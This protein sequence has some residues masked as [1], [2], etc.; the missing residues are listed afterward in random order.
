MIKNKL[1][2]IRHEKKYV[3]EIKEVNGTVAL[4]IVVLCLEVRV[5]FHS[6]AVYIQVPWPLN[7]VLVTATML[8]GAAGAGAYEMGMITDASSSLAFTGL[9][10]VVSAAGAIVVGFPP[11]VCHSQAKC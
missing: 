7:Y 1:K 5:V 10:V 11:L 2:E 3:Y 8:G 9:A 6:F 4:V